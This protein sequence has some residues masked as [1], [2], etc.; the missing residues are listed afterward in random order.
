MK[1]QEFLEEL[2]EYLVGIP[3]N[4]K[5]EI[6]QDYEEHFKIGKKKKRNEGEIVKTL[7][8]PKEIAREMRM[9]FSSSKKSELKSEAIET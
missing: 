6:M 4:E 1:K 7:G 2:E 5:E 3:S 8:E 9:T